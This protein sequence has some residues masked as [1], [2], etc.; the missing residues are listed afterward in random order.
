MAQRWRSPPESSSGKCS[1]RGD[2]PTSAQQ[3]ARAFLD[4]LLR[5]AAQMQRNGD[6]FD[7]GQG[8]QQIEELKNESDLVAAQARQFIVGQARSA[9]A[10]SISISPDDAVSRPPIR[11]S[12]VD[13]PEPDGP[14]MDTISP[15]P[16]DRST[17]SR[18]VTLRL[19]SKTLL[20]FASSDH[21]Y[22]YHDRKSMRIG[23]DAGGTFTDFIVVADDGAIET[24]KLRSNPR[25]PAQRNSGWSRASRGQRS[26]PR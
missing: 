18:A 2:K 21:A 17:F 26:A 9:A 22:C 5:P 12:S 7:A 23:I 24:F 11:F 15:R 10:P 8:G 19:P 20:T 6:V 4:F 1:R 13:L 16:M 14:T 25:S 3:L